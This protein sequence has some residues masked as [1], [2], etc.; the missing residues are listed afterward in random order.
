[1]SL[2]SEKGLLRTGADIGRADAVVFV[3]SPNAAR[4]DDALK[5]VTYAASLN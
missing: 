4:S 1:V 3:L 5:E 2:G